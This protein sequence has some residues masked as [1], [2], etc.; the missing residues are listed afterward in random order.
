ML[1][2]GGA[3]GGE[4]VA[5][6]ARWSARDAYGTAQLETNPADPY[7]VNVW[8]AAAGGY[9]YVMAADRE[10]RWA[11]HI[12]DA[13]QVRLK[14]CEDVYEL[15]AVEVTDAATRDAVIAAVRR[16]YDFEPTAEQRSRGTLFRMEP[17]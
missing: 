15:R 12:A 2:P 4:V 11:Q 3:L 10:N 8:G 9:F 1:L 16:K 13:P 14:V 6:P 7:S 17:R 5:P